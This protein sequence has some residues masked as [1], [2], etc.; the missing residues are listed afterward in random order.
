M[1]LF[2]PTEFIIFQII[3]I[4]VLLIIEFTLGVKIVDFQKLRNVDIWLIVRL[5]DWRL[6]A[7]DAFDFEPDNII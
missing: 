1:R 5:F 7:I 6:V 2:D 4:D 3:E